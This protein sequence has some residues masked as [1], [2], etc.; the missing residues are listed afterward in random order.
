M[1]NKEMKVLIVCRYKVKRPHNMSPFVYEQGKALERCGIDVMFYLIKG[2]SC[3]AYLKSFSSFRRVLSDFNPDVIHAHYGIVGLFANMFSNIPVVTTY[4][5]SDINY[6][7][8]LFLSRLAIRL[9]SLNVFVSAKNIVKSGVKQDYC[10]LPC[11]VDLN[12]LKLIDKTI[13]KKKL[14]W[15]NDLKYIIFAGAFDNYVKN[16][17]LAQRSVKL[18]NDVLL[19]E[20]TGYSREQ[21]V[22]LLCAADAFLM[23]SFTEGSPQVVKEAMACGCPVVSVDVGD[24]ADVI[25]GVDGCYIANR[26]PEDIAA[27]LNLA[28]AFK[29]R[30]KGRAR[31]VELGLSN[32]II[33][34]KLIEE[35]EY[36]LSK[37]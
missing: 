12:N 28:V 25:R 20:L 22:M 30:T 31:I 33:A 32:D 2:S 6:R 27:K 37:K 17:V 14:N 16:Y 13:A 23:T 29:G 34:R 8:A 9:S 5:G 36:V 1:I 18:L 21:V 10:L 7:T 35:Y 19:V 26:D 24:V 11:G 15:R 3:V 4:H